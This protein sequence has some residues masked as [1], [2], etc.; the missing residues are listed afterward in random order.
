MACS[1]DGP[2]P[3]GSALFH[4]PWHGPRV[5]DQGHFLGVPRLSE[6]LTW[7]NDGRISSY[8][9]A[10]SDGYTDTRY[11][12]YVPWS[13]RLTQESFNVSGSQQLTNNYTFDSGQAGELGVLTAIGT[14]A[15][16]TNTWSV[17]GSGGL[18]D[19]S[20]VSQEQHRHHPPPGHGLGPG[21]SQSHRHARWQPGQGAVRRHGRRWSLA[22][23]P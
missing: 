19:L 22:C 18:D 15:Q 9:G 6:T 7:R 1:S 5:A 3:R 2:T 10:R 20:R 14:P 23:Q 8:T 13:G 16:S 11:F 12:T 4:S 17:T 21:R